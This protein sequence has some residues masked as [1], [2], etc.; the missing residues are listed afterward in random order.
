MYEVILHAFDDNGCS[1]T[2]IMNVYA[3]SDLSVHIPNSF[4]VTGDGVNESFGP[5][6]S[7]PEKLKKFQIQIYNRWGEE[8]FLSTDITHFW[9]G[10]R[11]RK[12]KLVQEGV[13]TWKIKYTSNK[14]IDKTLVG[15]LSL[16]K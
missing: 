3:E 7:N 9:D 8:V 15:H 10:T 11:G 5:V 2:A 4:T 6:F 13:Y 1:D 16:L 14:D 12:N